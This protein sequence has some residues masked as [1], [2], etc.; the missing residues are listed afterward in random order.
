MKYS[1]FTFVGIKQH[2]VQSESPVESICSH[3]RRIHDDHRT[4]MKKEKLEMLLLFRLLLPSKDSERDIII[5]EILNEYK[6]S[7]DS[8][9]HISY[10]AKR[11]RKVKG[12][13]KDGAS[14]INKQKDGFYDKNMFCLSFCD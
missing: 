13:A 5:K 7:Y 6:K 10:R 12:K 2:Q 4:S 8:N 1:G 3:L 11:Y 9:H 14:T